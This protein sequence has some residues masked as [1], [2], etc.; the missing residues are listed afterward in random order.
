M[1][2][3]IPQEDEEIINPNPLINNNDNNDNNGLIN[4]NDLDQNNRE[5]NNHNHERKYFSLTLS[6][7]AILLINTILLIYSFFK[8]IDQPKYIFQFE[9]IKSHYQYYRF[10]TRYFIHFSICHTLVE[11]YF[12]YFIFRFCENVFGTIITLS[13]IFISFIIVSLLQ[14]I[15]I[16]AL[17]FFCLIF[18]IRSNYYLD[19]EGGL[20]PVLFAMNTFYFSFKLSDTEL[21]SFLTF[22][23]CKRKYISFIVLVILFIAT[24][25]HYS[26][27]GNICGILTGYCIKNHHWLL[28][29]VKWVIDFEDSICFKDKDLIY[30]HITK[31]NIFM[32]R[33]FKEFENSILDELISKKMIN[34]EDKEGGESNKVIE[35]SNFEN[36][37]N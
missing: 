27:L 26:L 3:N 29:R 15:I 9:L 23:F 12:C 28:P 4:N 36:K 16:I 33:F 7:M 34:S 30:R 21:I 10:I 5:R 31:D 11:L 32:Q 20:T 2:N 24:P 19:Y 17:H 8:P 1:N 25:N 6:F 13:F 35:M 18:N 14:F 37:T 22:F